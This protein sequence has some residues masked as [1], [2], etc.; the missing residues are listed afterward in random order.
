MIR[1][2][3]NRFPATA[4]PSR[5]GRRSMALGLLNCNDIRADA[6]AL[7]ARTLQ[8]QDAQC[9][10]ASRPHPRSSTGYCSDIHTVPR[11]LGSAEIASTG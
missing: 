7:I 8:P 9:R 4:V 6:A 2:H 5:E 1:A 3:E 10:K 11:L